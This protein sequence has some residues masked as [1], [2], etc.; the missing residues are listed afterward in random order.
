MSDAQH[1]YIVAYDIS[2]D[3]R[4]LR[5][6]TVLQSFGDRVQYS[7]FLVDIKPAR[8]V[9]LR[10]TLVPLMDLSTDALFICDVGPVTG[11]ARH[12]MEFIGRA[13]AIT[14]N[15]PAVF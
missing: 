6:A 15:G 10:R 9:R 11:E 14:G 5:I 12:R 3:A 13:R 7:V 4:R 2:D 1:R 8:L